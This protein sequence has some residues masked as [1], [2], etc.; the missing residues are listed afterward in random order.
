MQQLLV[1]PR[2]LNIMYTKSYPL[3][4]ESKSSVQETVSRT[5]KIRIEST[6]HGTQYS[7]AANLYSPGTL[8]MFTSPYVERSGPGTRNMKYVNL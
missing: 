6:R 5:C 1:D 8:C 7:S 3:H 2:D 4:V